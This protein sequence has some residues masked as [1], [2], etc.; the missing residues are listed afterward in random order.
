MRRLLALA[1]LLVALA[2]APGAAAAD[3]PGTD[4]AA[5]TPRACADALALLDDSRPRDAVALV[6]AYRATATSPADPAARATACAD[7]RDAAVAARDTAATLAAEA[8]ALE[9]GGARPTSGEAE[10]WAAAQ[11]RAEQALALDAQ[12]ARA[13]A[14]VR[15]AQ[16][17]ETTVPDRAASAWDGFVEVVSPLGPPLLALLVGV[18]VLAV[19]ARLVVPVTLR[20]P[21]LSASERVRAGAA[22]WGAL[23]A[24]AALLVWGPAAGASTWT[25]SGVAGAAL[26][27]VVLVLGFVAG[28]VAVALALG[29]LVA[30]G[31]RHDRTRWWA[32]ATAV[33][34]VAAVA[35]VVLSARALGGPGTVAAGPVAAGSLAAGAV[36]AALGVLLVA[37]VLATRLR[38]TIEVTSGRS[39][40][41]TTSHEGTGGARL[42][43]LLGELGAEPPRGLE[44]PRG[45]DISA[46]SGSA[47][48]EL[49]QGAFVKAVV[50]LAQ[51]VVGS[52]P[53]RVTVEE[54]DADHLA[55]VVTRNGRAAG[56][57]A[58]DRAG[59]LRFD[60]ED[61]TSAAAAAQV[62]LYR[63]AAAV[64]LLTLARH[65][66]GFEGLCGATS[67]RS[68]AL[69][70]VAQSDLTDAPDRERELLAR[71]VDVDPRNDL[72]QVA[73]AHAEG[74]HHTL[75]EDLDAYGR[76]LDRFV[77][78]TAGRSGYRSLRLRAQYSRAATTVNACFAP[79]RDGDD[80]AGGL[81]ATA[82]DAVRALLE[83]LAVERAAGREDAL[84]VRLQDAVESLYRQA[85]AAARALEPV[86]PQGV[87]P[88]PGTEP[89]DRAGSS[90]TAESVATAR[91]A[92]TSR[93]RLRLAYRA[94]LA[95]DPEGADAP[96]P[97]TPTGE[98][99]LACTYAVRTTPLGAADALRTTDH[100]RRAVVLADLRAWLHDDPMLAAYRER[101]EYAAEFGQD[102]LD[103]LA[104]APFARYAPALRAWGLT[105]EQRI[106][107]VS[108][109][110]LA[111]LLGTTP[112]E[113]ATVRAAAH[114]AADLPALPGRCDVLDVLLVHDVG[115]LPPAGQGLP[116]DVAR[117]VRSRVVRLRLTSSE[118][119]RLR[120][121]LAGWLG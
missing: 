92:E 21:V 116:D 19:V 115:A 78:R 53:W 112:E 50:S 26:A 90:E 97:T 30:P 29:R 65:H 56:S 18:L 105:T 57:A 99:N 22:G 89:S 47:L 1:A 77:A 121:A 84:V 31:A 118:R 6:D 69:Q 72:A 58:L 100:L 52:V 54:R 24:G 3:A 37:T 9:P 44:V 17:E 33:D 38:L 51:G 2:P 71:A 32:W 113:A 49:P 98:Y 61:P 59:L 4:P 73:L 102:P 16:E 40:D 86:A 23:V 107:A 75:R 82:V 12:D 60:P 64:V 20:W 104:V 120:A 111:A 66:A 35:A 110:D 11:A 79:G 8:E 13:A 109:P 117:A 103:L 76:W 85:E 108:P 41:R 83:A 46:L 101:P 36:V 42:V 81:D 25:G 10:S 34:G 7:V 28:V 106:V 55:V 43:A 74:R 114:L 96:S 48:S 5:T 91:S 119:D 45:T 27:V 87:P 80:P 95:R 62:D 63:A 39:G 93:E 94:A 15:A 68:L 70:Y 88:A 14:V 67:W